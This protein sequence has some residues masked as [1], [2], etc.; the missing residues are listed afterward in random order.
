MCTAHRQA[1]YSL[2]DLTLVLVIIGITL[3]ASLPAI[4]KLGSSSNLVNSSDQI[5][6]HLRLARQKAVARGVSH[7]VAWDETTQQYAIVMDQNANGLPDSAESREGPFDLP[8][9][10]TLQNSPSQ[11]FSASMLMFTPGGSAS[12]SGT[13]VLSNVR[14]DSKNL[15]V[16][17][18][19]GHVRVH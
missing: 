7:I 13:V 4:S 15:S 3:A 5:A 16:L 19:T 1:G 17:A 9:G 8:N 12:E 14:G 18:P 2:L 11:G 6:G 10:V